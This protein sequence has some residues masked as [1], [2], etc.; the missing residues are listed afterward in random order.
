MNSLLNNTSNTISKKSSIKQREI[1][2]YTYY[3]NPTQKFLKPFRTSTLN[4]KNLKS[5]KF[6][7]PKKTNTNTI[8]TKRINKNKTN[9]I[10]KINSLNH[11]RRW[12]DIKEKRGS[13]ESSLF[14]FFQK[15]EFFDEIP[16]K[17]P[18]NELN[19]ISFSTNEDNNDYEK[20]FQLSQLSNKNIIE[21]NEINNDLKKTL[22]LSKNNTCTTFRLS[23][24]DKKDFLYDHED[25]FE[26]DENKIGKNNE[27]K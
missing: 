13:K 1:R 16:K 2:R 26:E 25:S 23:N 18:T 24:L 21:L 19:Y 6:D 15:P 22:V 17:I 14:S 3:F 4:A 12:S 7:I 9:N 27:K 5:V 20:I 8:F 10:N 11:Y